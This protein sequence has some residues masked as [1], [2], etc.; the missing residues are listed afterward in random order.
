[1]AVRQD[2]TSKPY[3]CHECGNKSID[4]VVT[5]DSG[6]HWMRCASCGWSG[7]AFNYVFESLNEDWTATIAA[8]NAVGM[9]LKLKDFSTN[10]FSAHSKHVKL[11]RNLEQIAKNMAHRRVGAQ[12]GQPYAAHNHP[13]W[14]AV[15]EPEFCQYLEI[16]TSAKNHNESY[17][18]CTAVPGYDRMMR[19]IGA[20]LYE[21]TK[22]RIVCATGTY[23]G[24]LFRHTIRPDRR[25]YV[26]TDTRDDIALQ[27]QRLA[28][29]NGTTVPV[30]SL[31]QMSYQNIDKIASDLQGYRV[32]IV[33]DFVINAIPV[34]WMSLAIKMNADLAP[35]G[36]EDQSLSAQMICDN[37]DKSA[38]H[39][40]EVLLTLLNNK[41]DWRIR[42]MVNGVGDAEDVMSQ[43][44][45]RWS[46]TSYEKLRAVVNLP[47][48]DTVELRKDLAVYDSPDGVRDVRTNAVLCETVP[49]VTAVGFENSR[50]VY[51]GYV[52]YRGKCFNFRSR[53][54]KNDPMGV[55]EST[56]LKAG[57]TDFA[58]VHPKLVPYLYTMARHWGVV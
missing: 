57:I 41:P 30:T 10:E 7:Y 20:V 15:T 12:P 2:P 5:D 23:G 25:V 27:V 26:S 19:P 42:A 31:V 21:G 28:A 40:S 29:T 50:I 8:L 18:I 17:H 56:M 33:R 46:R 58:P 16:K 32:T 13:S 52:R 22:N 37:W 4:C 53:K 34:D 14:W 36:E 35:V 51:T 1:M 39:W 49:Y 55:I 6:Q 24:V 11:I 38:V 48:V 54:F 45:T 43:L 44:K 9:K 47:L 3:Y